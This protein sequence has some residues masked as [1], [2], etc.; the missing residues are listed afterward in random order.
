MI[1]PLPRARQ[2]LANVAEVADCHG[3]PRGSFG[4]DFCVGGCSW[5]CVAPDPEMLGSSTNKT[6]PHGAAAL[7]AQMHDH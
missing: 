3:S 7:G 6:M 4:L 1:G 5:L 2:T